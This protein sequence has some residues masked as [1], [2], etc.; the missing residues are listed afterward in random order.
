MRLGFG[1]LTV[2]QSLLAR[3]RLVGGAALACLTLFV[4]LALIAPF[5][6]RLVTGVNP[7]I[8]PMKFAISIAIFL[9]TIAWFMPDLGPWPR[10][11]R[12]IAGIVVATMTVELVAIVGQAARGTTSH[13][14]QSSA[15]DAAVFSI[16]GMAITVN[17]L[18]VAAMLPLV[19]RDVPVARA[20]YLF[21]MR[22]GMA[23]FVI[24]SLL[25]FAIVTNQGHS[26]PGP[27]GGP[28]LPFLNWAVDQGDL[29]VA[30]FI[31]LHA[32]QALPLLGFVLDRR[33]PAPVART[34][35]L[36]TVAAIWLAVM[37]ATLLLALAGRP[38]LGS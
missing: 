22:L 8:K 26:V 24:G 34:R 38:L 13:F 20:G 10:A 14:N 2:L 31:G 4:G 35:V 21:G 16:M 37:G 12:W 23:L 27:D 6:A 18:A 5:D 30:H 7:W 29:R 11:R 33:Q 17:T 3:D 32:L 25:G 15:F 28:G 9:A 36:S 1:D 19:R